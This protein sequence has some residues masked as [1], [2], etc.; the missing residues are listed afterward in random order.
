LCSI[1]EFQLSVVQ[2]STAVQS[3]D[4]LIRQV[5]RERLEH[6]QSWGPDKRYTLKELLGNSQAMD[7][8]LH[9]R[10]VAVRDDLTQ[11]INATAGRQAAAF[12]ADTDKL[13]ASIANSLEKHQAALRQ[14]CQD[15]LQRWND[16]KWYRRLWRWLKKLGELRLEH[17]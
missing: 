7:D 1:R 16:K 17:P 2:R 4:L 9:A 3:P 5:I 11:F 13:T 12:R 10:M 14:W 6:E 8:L 15:E